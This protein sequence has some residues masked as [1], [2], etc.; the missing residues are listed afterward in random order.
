MAQPQPLTPFVESY[1]FWDVVTL[2]ARERL[3]HDEI[4]ARVLARAFVCD[5][6]RIQ[7]IDTRWV[8]GDDRGIE[9]RGYP[10]VG[11]CANPELPM[12]VLRAEALE[13][14]LAIVQRAE[15]P[16]REKLTEEFV[17]REDFRGWA[18]A[19]ELRLPT[20]WFGTVTSRGL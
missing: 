18:A 4:V 11:F 16:Q 8:K 17:L 2:W 10:Y 3:E 1:R 13:H 12:C 20:F 6:L 19:T 14:L 9:F 5:G 15:L 7:S